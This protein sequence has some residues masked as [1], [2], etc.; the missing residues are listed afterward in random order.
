MTPFYPRSPYGSA[1]AC[2][3]WIAVN[4]LEACGIH[5]PHGILRDLVHEMV[6]EDLDDALRT[7]VLR[8]AGFEVR[9]PR[10]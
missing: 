10:K 7:D 4:N 5:A 6:H 1:K 3:Y 9:E 8:K 2:A